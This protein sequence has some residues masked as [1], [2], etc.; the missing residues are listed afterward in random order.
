VIYVSGYASDDVEA[1]GPLPSERSFL[2]K[3]FSRRA[4]LGAVR[5]LLDAP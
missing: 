3:P 4:L 5:R 2:R 1:D